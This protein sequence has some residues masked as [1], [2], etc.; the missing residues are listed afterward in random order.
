MW[1]PNGIIL[2]LWLRV[3]CKLVHLLWNLYFKMLWM[4]KGE[5]QESEPDH[6]IPRNL[7][8]RTMT[9]RASGYKLL[10]DGE[11]QLGNWKCTR[12]SNTF[13][14]IPALGAIRNDDFQFLPLSPHAFPP[15]NKWVPN[16]HWWRGSWYTVVEQDH[17]SE[18]ESALSEKTPVSKL[19]QNFQQ[20]RD[21][22]T[23]HQNWLM[24]SKAHKT[25]EE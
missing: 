8:S 16:M 14:N 24:S 4:S 23:F 3:V 7:H 10:S 5:F 25:G 15:Q 11:L 21:Y 1:S 2:R 13:F 18:R 12:S 22:K 17:T 6:L 20:R 9:I 19:H